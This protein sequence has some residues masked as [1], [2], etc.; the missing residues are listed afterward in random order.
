M[1]S[2]P[3]LTG[4]LETALYVADVS[5][6]VAWYQRLFGF[7]LLSR[8]ERMAALRVTNDQLLL[9]FRHG[10]STAPIDTPGGIIPPHDATGCIHF[11]FAIPT[12]SLTA[13]EARLR[14]HGVTVDGRVNWSRGGISLY[15]YDPDGHLV[16]LATP[17]IWPNY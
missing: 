2:P 1:N 13:W 16:E 5:R 6:S 17:G 4:I 11:A 12:D 9:L 7:E 14:H 10:G 8:D 3:P 15:F